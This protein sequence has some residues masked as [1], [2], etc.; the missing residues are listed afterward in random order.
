[1]N[2]NTKPIEHSRQEN[3]RFMN[4]TQNNFNKF[5]E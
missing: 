3:K 2:P 1:M 5:E 4:Q